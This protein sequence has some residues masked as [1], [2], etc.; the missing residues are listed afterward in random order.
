MID[1]YVLYLFNSLCFQFAETRHAS[2][3]KPHPLFP[4]PLLLNLTVGLM[5][6]RHLT[7]TVIAVMKAVPTVL[8]QFR[9]RT[10]IVIV[11]NFCDPI[12]DFVTVAM[13]MWMFYRCGK[14]VNEE[15]GLERL[16][17][18]SNEAK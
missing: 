3:L 8:A 13:L 14:F 17:A 16:F 7:H 5:F 12:I 10:L 18:D 9:T 11:S 15:G 1:A 4:V 2:G 6:T